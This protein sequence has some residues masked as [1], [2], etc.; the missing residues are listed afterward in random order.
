M[1]KVDAK[2]DEEKGIVMLG[3]EASK[4]EEYEILDMIY[5]ILDQKCESKIGYIR[6]NRLVGHF[7]GVIAPAGPTDNNPA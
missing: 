2:L 6:S 3:F 7:K 4:E 5:H 1:I